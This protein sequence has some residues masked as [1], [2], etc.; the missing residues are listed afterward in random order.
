[1]SNKAAAALLA[2][3]VISVA[4]SLGLDFVPYLMAVTFDRSTSFIAPV[5][6]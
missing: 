5:G 1:M 4:H 3:I 6:N 2:P